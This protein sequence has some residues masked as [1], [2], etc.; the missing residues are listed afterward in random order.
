MPRFRSMSEGQRSTIL[1][2]R[3]SGRVASIT[4]RRADS[5]SSLEAL[6]M[7]AKDSLYDSR[8]LRLRVMSCNDGMLY[9]QPA[10]LRPSAAKSYPTDPYDTSAI[11]IR[12]PMQRSKQ[13]ARLFHETSVQSTDPTGPDSFNPLYSLTDHHSSA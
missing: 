11:S 1:Y 5:A 10:A 13:T 7:Q 3:E 12:P 9:H 8:A 6:L 2:H 4:C